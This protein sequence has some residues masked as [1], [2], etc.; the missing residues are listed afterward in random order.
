MSEE[1]CFTGNYPL[2]RLKLANIHRYS[3]IYS[4]EVLSHYVY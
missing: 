4:E 1:N 2:L 3:L